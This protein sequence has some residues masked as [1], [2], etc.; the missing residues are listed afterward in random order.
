MNNLREY[1]QQLTDDEKIKIINGHEQLERDG[2]IGD[3]PIRIHTEQF[4]ATHDVYNALIP[5]WMNMM[6]FECH[7]HF[8]MLAINTLI[9]NDL[10]PQ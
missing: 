6:A 3:E 5:V 4:L 10:Y 2:F 1:V 7:R 9:L 8:S